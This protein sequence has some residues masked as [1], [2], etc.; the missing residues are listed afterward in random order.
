MLLHLFW[1]ATLK[2]LELGLWPVGFL[3]FRVT[4]FSMIS[5]LVRMPLRLLYS[6]LRRL[7]LGRLTKIHL[8]C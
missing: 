6:H 7:F 4:K 8:I 5:L 2:N 3:S 1:D